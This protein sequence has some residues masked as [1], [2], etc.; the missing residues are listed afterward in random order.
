MATSTINVNNPYVSGGN[1]RIYNFEIP[2]GKS[3][4]LSGGGFRGFL[5]TNAISSPPQG[6]YILGKKNDGTNH[7]L[8]EV[9]SSTVISVTYS[10]GEFIVTNNSANAV[11]GCMLF[12]NGSQTITVS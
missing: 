1:I 4:T 12:T 11:V 2:I 5:I 3:A 6:M 8:T 10:N 7:G 9:K